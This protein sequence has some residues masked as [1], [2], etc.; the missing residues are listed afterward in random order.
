MRAK[1]K[2]SKKGYDADV[3]A[4]QTGSR[5]CIELPDSAVTNY[6]PPCPVVQ[7]GTEG[8]G[9]LAIAPFCI[10]DLRASR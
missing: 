7:E 5:Q 2:E 4:Q 6:Q 3:I 1:Q 9:V 10:V 8:E